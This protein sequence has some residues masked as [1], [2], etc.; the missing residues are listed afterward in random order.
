MVT[1]KIKKVMAFAREAGGVAAIGPVCQ[2]ILKVGWELLLLS[3]DHGLDVFKR[4]N[5]DCVDFPVFDKHKL[6]LLVNEKFKSLP[7]LIFNS[8]TSLPK[9]DMTERYLWEWGQKHNIPTIGVV[10]QWQNY[11]VRFSGVGEKDRLAYLPDYIFIMDDF[12]K[13]EMISNG[14]PEN[15]LVVTGNPTFDRLRKTYK[16]F[17]LQVDEIKKRINITTDYMVFTFVAESLRKDFGTIIGYDEHATLRTLGNI[18]D[19]LNSKADGLQI[20]LI[21]K[22]HPENQLKEFDWVYNEWPLLAKKII[23]DELIPYEVIAISDV[24][25][26]I[27]S[28]MLLEALLVDRIVV[29]LQINS[30]IESQMVAT[31]SGA[32]PF[33]KTEEVARMTIE[34]LFQSK[35]YRKDYLKKQRG[36]K[37]KGNATKKCIDFMRSLN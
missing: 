27:S 8:A 9:L 1:D 36:W 37:V 7:D 14:L 24:L 22:L 16:T 26:G 6:S 3:K 29:S 32:I 20:F 19:Q 18:L 2:A 11:A 12:A 5:L 15:R 21:I 28:V 4:Y 35:E 30:S 17:E 33:I 34:N 13:N 31:R 23:K 25:V 10:D